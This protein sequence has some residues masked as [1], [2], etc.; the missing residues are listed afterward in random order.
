MRVAWLLVALAA[1]KYDTLPPLTGDAQRGS[2]AQAIDSAIDSKVFMDA[3]PDGSGPRSLTAQWTLS[4]VA[5]QMQT[6]QAFYPTAVLHAQQYDPNT[7]VDIGG[8]LTTFT[9]CSLRTGTLAGL[10]TAHY[11]TWLTITDSAMAQVWGTSLPT[12]LD[13]TMSDQTVTFKLYT[14][15]GYFKV[16]WKLL[17]A[18]SNNLL[19]CAQAG[20]KT[21]DVLSTLS[22]TT[23]ASDDQYDCT[24][25][26]GITAVL[27]MGTYN[28]SLSALD[29]NMNA[30]AT[31]NL[32]NEQIAGQNAITDLGTVTLSIPGK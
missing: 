3:A 8:E 16:A 24:A 15:G 17:G 32:A 9:Q 18:N 5:G 1:C 6:C 28:E 23:T 22:G 13:F 2:D 11:R 4:N 25:G 14:D 19:T 21:F 10:A 26:S 27:V 29:A 7:M 31:Q 12:N 30:V 20:A